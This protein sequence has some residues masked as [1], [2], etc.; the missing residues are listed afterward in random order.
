MR[1]KF[2]SCFGVINMRENYSHRS[3]IKNSCCMMM[4]KI[5]YSY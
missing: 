5:W 4:D 3:T 2:F 1:N